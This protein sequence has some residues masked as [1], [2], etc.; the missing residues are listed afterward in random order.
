MATNTTSIRSNSM[1]TGGA[2]ATQPVS[3]TL[4]PADIQAL[5]AAMTPAI[6]QFRQASSPLSVALNQQQLTNGQEDS[7]RI[8]SVGLGYRTIS[9][10]NVTIP[11][12][13]TAT[14]AQVI[15]ISPYFPYNLLAN[16]SVQINGGATSYSVDGQNGLFV[17]LRGK[18]G[19]FLPSSTGVSLSPALCRVTFGTGITPTASSGFSLSGYSSISVAATTSTSIT[20]TFYTF[21][22]LA[23]SRNT[24]LGALPLQN[25]QVYATLSRRIVANVV[26]T[27]ALS[28]L[29]VSGGVPST[30]TYSAMDTINT[31][32]K[33]WSVPSNPALYTDMIT[34]SY[35]VLQ[36][37][38]NPVNSNGV[39]A[40]VYNIPQNQYLTALHLL[41]N[42]STGAYPE[43]DTLFTKYTLQYNGGA[44]IP[45]LEYGQR[46]RAESYLDYGADVGG[47]LPGYFLWD[48]NNTTD[49]VNTSD[50]AGW[51]DAYSAA[52]PQV[53][54]DIATN[55]STP[56]NFS[57][58]REAIVAGSVQTIG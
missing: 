49:D 30:L 23:M 13:N 2:T 27:S 8:S 32:Y 17:A 37:P 50:E 48:G 22:K 29:Y 15:D 40:L 20:L 55:F 28:P 42:D 9:E 11:L 12:D 21:E 52:S 1:P 41:V 53:V 58:T 18:R 4:T 39:G 6:E 34:N 24:L 36:Q 45:T 14:T 5:L 57:V 19:A 56:G 7:I 47:S 51:M 3:P 35:Q 33:F 43:P 44:I 16:T 10:H 46:H 26:G 38:K 31:T 25:N 54:A